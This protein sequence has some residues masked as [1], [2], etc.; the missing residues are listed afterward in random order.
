MVGMVGMQKNENFCKNELSL[1]PMPKWH[2]SHHIY[3]IIRRKKKKS[4]RTKKEKEIKIRT[5][6]ENTE[7]GTNKANRHLCLEP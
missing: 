3:N 6:W 4:Q 5:K 7:S 2:L 1:D